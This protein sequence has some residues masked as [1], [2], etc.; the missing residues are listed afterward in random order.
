MTFVDLGTDLCLLGSV[1]DVGN[2][3][4][5]R[6]AIPLAWA[7]PFGLVFLRTFNNLNA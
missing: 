2:R 7:G 6:I 5:D 3:H 4:K 1:M